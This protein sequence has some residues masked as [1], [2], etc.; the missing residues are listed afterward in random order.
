MWRIPSQVIAASMGGA[1]PVTQQDSSFAALGAGASYVSLV[2]SHLFSPIVDI[3][4]AMDQIGSLQLECAF[5]PSGAG[6]TFR[7]VDP[8][9]V[10]PVVNPVFTII[11]YRVPNLLSRW[12]LTNPGGVACTFTEFVIVYRSM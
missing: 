7:P 11:D 2:F 8:P 6:S 10:V 4:I 5:A 1:V 3:Y 9:F 12:T